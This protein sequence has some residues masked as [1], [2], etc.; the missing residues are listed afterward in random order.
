MGHSGHSG[1]V[2][3]LPSRGRMPPLTPTAGDPPASV[4]PFVLQLVASTISPLYLLSL[5]TGVTYFGAAYGACAAALSVQASVPT[6]RQTPPVSL[7]VLC[8]VGH[9]YPAARS[10]RVPK[11]IECTIYRRKSISGNSWLEATGETS[12]RIPRA[13]PCCSVRRWGR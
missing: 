10:L 6:S 8:G 5:P 3:S 4:L 11:R 7:C 1:F 2:A 13:E 12:T 9:S